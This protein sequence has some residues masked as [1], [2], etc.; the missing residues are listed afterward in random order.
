M[1]SRLLGLVVA[2]TPTVGSVAPDF[3]VTD[4]DGNTVNLG[5]WVEG[6]PVV[7]AFFPKAYTPG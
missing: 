7:V 6:G 3:V 5:K 1:L 2:S 4:I